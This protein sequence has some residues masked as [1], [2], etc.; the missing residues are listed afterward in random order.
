MRASTSPVGNRRHVTSSTSPPPSTW[1][2]PRRPD[3]S[4]ARPSMALHA[5]E[6]VANES[7]SVRRGQQLEGAQI[8]D[9]VG[10]PGQRRRVVEVA[11]RRHV[12]QQ[13]VVAHQRRPAPSVSSADRPIRGPIL[14]TSSSP[15]PRSGRPDSP[16]RDRG[17]AHRAP[18]GRPGAPDR[19]AAPPRP[20]P[21]TSDGRPC[22]GGTRCVA[23]RA[24][25][26]AHSGSMRTIR[27][28]WSSASQHRDRPLALQQE[29]DELVD[30]A[31]RPRPGQRLD[32]GRQTI[33]RGTCDRSSSLRADATAQAAA[34]VPGR[35]RSTPSDARCTSPR[36]DDDARCQR[37]RRWPAA[38][39]TDGRGTPSEPRAPSR[40][41]G[42]TVAKRVII[43][44]ADAVG[45]HIGNVVLVVEPQDLLGAI[46]ARDAGRL[47]RRSN[48]S[49]GVGRRRAR[50]SGWN[51]RSAASSHPTRRCVAQPTAAH[52]SGRAP[53]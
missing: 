23:A 17:T 26:G 18:A 16:C 44:R 31:G 30:G 34:P 7:A 51:R 25:T 5:V 15:P 35:R 11:P 3:R 53:A 46:G 13:Q 4:P 28:A 22:S 43:A 14:A 37:S 12:G 8:A 52:A 27:F 41:R 9:G 19:P 45:E 50:S 1:P 49:L 21:P 24:R 38:D 6:P 33:E 42:P 47:G 2:D 32:L 10:D 39:R 29:R 40:D 36:S 20:R 48:T